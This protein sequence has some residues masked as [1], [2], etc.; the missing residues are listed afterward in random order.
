M[1]GLIVDSVI[2]DILVLE[3]QDF[4]PSLVVVAVSGWEARPQ[5]EF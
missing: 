5:L 3:E 2:K 4:N 1:L